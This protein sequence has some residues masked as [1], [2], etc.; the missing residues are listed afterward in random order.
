MED[1]TALKVLASLPDPVLGRRFQNR[2]ESDAL[3][4]C[5]AVSW[6]DQ[7]PSVI[8][9]SSFLREADSNSLP[10]VTDVS[11]C[12]QLRGAGGRLLGVLFVRLL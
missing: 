3:V 4:F 7:S 8:Y 11:Y 6:A 1:G 5:M 12:M 9:L 10:G 2:S